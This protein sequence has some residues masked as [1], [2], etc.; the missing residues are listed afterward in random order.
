MKKLLIRRSSNISPAPTKLKFSQHGVAVITDSHNHYTGGRYNDLMQSILFNDLI[1][2]K[3][4]TDNDILFKDDFCAYNLPEII[5]VGS[6]NLDKLDVYADCYFGPQTDGLIYA[7]KMASKYNKPAIISMYDSPMWLDKNEH[8]HKTGR[9]DFEQNTYKIIKEVLRQHINNIPSL[10]ILVLTDNSIPSYC[11]YF[12]LP[13]SYFVAVH[14]T[15]NEKLIEAINKC[16]IPKE[17]K[18]V[19]ISRNDSRKNWKETFEIFSFLQTDYKLVIISNSDNNFENYMS[20]F[21]VEKDNVI[22]MIHPNDFVKFNQIKSSQLL[23]STSKFEGYGMW[24]AEA[25]AC[26]VPVA[27]KDLPSIREIKNDNV[28]FLPKEAEESASK[29]KEFISDNQD[30]A[31]HLISE[32]SNVREQ[33]RTQLENSNIYFDKKHERVFEY[34]KIT[35]NCEPTID[36]AIGTRN[37]IDNFKESLSWLSLQSVASKMNLHILNGNNNLEILTFLR[38]I[39]DKFASVHLF[40]DSQLD[41]SRDWPSLYN[42]LLEQGSSKY[43]CFWSDDILC[44]NKECFE[45]GIRELEDNDK[46]GALIFGDIDDPTRP[47]GI[48]HV[49]YTPLG[50]P[51][52]NFGIIRRSAIEQAGGFDTS[53]FKFYHADSDLTLAI[54]HEDWDIKINKKCKVI[55]KQCD[56]SNDLGNKHRHDEDNEKLIQKWAVKFPDKRYMPL[57]NEQLYWQRIN[58]GFEKMRNSRVVVCGCCQNVAY[59]EANA[60]LNVNMYRVEYLRSLFKESACVIFE[61][62]SGDKTKEVLHKWRVKDVDVVSENNEYFNEFKK[63]PF[64]KDRMS[65][66]SYC[67]NRYMNVAKTLYGD[68]DY[69]ITLDLDIWA[70]FSYLGIANTFGQDEEWSVVASNGLRSMWI[71]ERGKQLKTPKTLHWDAY[72]FRDKNDGFKFESMSNID[73]TESEELFIRNVQKNTFLVGKEMVEVDSA[74]GGL[75]VYKMEDI[76]DCTYTGEHGVSE[77]ISLHRKIRDKGKKIFLN[78]S[79]IFLYNFNSMCTSTGHKTDDPNRDKL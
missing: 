6:N 9:H 66:M 62:N 13:K 71:D 40:Y 43:F 24:C 7:L 48:K 21:G 22:V 19:S 12:N 42:F 39:V 65:I 59:A 33:L 52:I 3:I 15:V 56:W 79:Q 8:I 47:P 37:R 73:M 14:P 46:L 61:N 1:Q 76:L 25:I 5:N 2:T 49:W 67:R 64:S 35:P 34:H 31:P 75:A 4:Y 57:H 74:F 36:I 78:P 10:K 11:E 23:L 44:S 28:L 27:C 41:C 16:D 77:H 38:G 54:Y 30:V 58:S 68:F 45:L 69:L 53:T 72:A 29:I 63:T 60:P 32:Q 51:C 17:N 18:I 50:L 70:G 20:E 55:H 26:G